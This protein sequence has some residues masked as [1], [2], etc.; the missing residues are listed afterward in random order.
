MITEQVLN[1]ERI[2]NKSEKIDISLT[3][4]AKAIK[5]QLKKDYP[6]CKFSITTQFYS[7]GRSLHISIMETDFKIIMPFEEL[8][9]VAILRY[10]RDG[11]RNKEDLKNLQEKR[12]HQIGNIYENEFYNSDVWNN[13][14]FLTEKGFNLVKRITELT[15]KFNWDN[16]DTQIDYFDVKFY[17]YLSLGKGE[18][19]LKENI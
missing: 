11:F 13:G 2:L 7:M 9:E 18:K 19:D 15:N 12:N 8:S 3:D 5:Q 1:E 10:T 17:T 16:S 4:I 14:V 6:F